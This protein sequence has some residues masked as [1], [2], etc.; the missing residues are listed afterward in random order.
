[1]LYVINNKYYVKV[2]RKFIPVEINYKNDDIELI[3]NRKN[4]I[5]DNGKVKYTTQIIDEKFKD[6]FKPKKSNYE[7]NRD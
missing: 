4:Y 3:P 2:G 5:E 1:M 6:S 7:L